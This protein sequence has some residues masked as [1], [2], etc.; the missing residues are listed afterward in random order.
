[1]FKNYLKLA[2]RNLFKQKLFSGLNILGLAT[3]L[4]SSIF[5]FLWVQDEISYD[6]FNVNAHKIYRI[7]T[8]LS[9]V[10]IANVPPPLAAAVK[11]EI[12]L[13]KNSTRL[14]SVKKVVTAGTSRF[15]EKRIYYTDSNFLNVFSYPLL[16]GEAA[17]VLTAPDAVVITEST[18]RKYFGKTEGAIGKTIYID[19]NIDGR[20][21]IVTGIL[22]DVPSNSHL[23]FDILLPIETYDK[24]G[25][26]GVWDNYSA[27]VYFQLGK[28]VKAT[29]SL[30]KRIEDQINL[31]KN[32][33]DKSKIQSKLSIQLL[34][35]IHLH[36]SFMDDVDGQGNAK[37]VTI[38]S[39]IAILILLIA[40]INFTNLSTAISSK[41]AK[42]VG[43][44]KTT[45]AQ[46]Y[47]LIGQFIGESVLLSLASLVIAI[48]VVILLLPLFNELASKSISITVLSLKVVGILITASVVIGIV[49]GSYPAFILSSF[50]PIRVLKGVTLFQGAK[51]SLRGGLVVLQFS[52]SVVL[53]IS[54]LVVYKQLQFIQQRDIG[55]DKENLLYIHMPEVGDLKDNKDALKAILRNHSAV[56]NYTITDHL[57]TYLKS[58]GPLTWTG[59]NSRKQVL[60]ARMRTDENFI[61]TFGVPLLAGRFFSGEI[62]SDEGMYVINETALKAMNMTL[63]NVIGQK[64]KVHDKE[65]TV[66]GV[67]KD[68]NFKPLQ[69]PV[70]PLVIKNNSSGGY[71]VVR[72]TQ[73][74]FKNVLSEMK[75]VFGKLY[76]D[77]PFS[78]GFVD[79]EMAR[80]YIAEERMSKL[81]N[82][83]SIL[84][85]LI[86][87]L[88]LFGLT[89]FSIQNRVK[90]IGIRK[91]IGASETS[92]VTLISKDFIKLVA[93][94]L[95]IAFPIASIVMN[96]W[97]NSFAYH[98]DM[99]WWMFAFGGL[100]AI[101]I[102][103]VTIS[104][105]AIKAAMA[106]P[107]KSLRA[108]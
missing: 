85:I 53:I 12:P 62:K 1:M 63:S 38:F 21:L 91:V 99:T 69:E 11:A 45:G 9:D 65:G 79:S 19:D 61:R 13:I 82:I 92:I 68:F 75:K 10:S 83:F 39:L 108:E 57:P 17:T 8:Q 33:N 35:D 7:T 29:P 58:A 25:N 16:Q 28:K 26:A 93:L 23:Q 42:E 34:T 27:Y 104:F 14:V 47:Q 64:I 5:I 3:G 66:I 88:G 67:I 41:R 20:N 24:N 94:A 59:M 18:A 60:S 86:S 101:L 15:E 48:L 105:Q 84:S 52:I 96:Q 44:R 6:N 89:T 56:S 74:N 31:I 106:N 95:I 90:E 71:A 80:L 73:A 70:G 40:C 81:F 32:R 46:R 49:A 43:L 87:S 50:N 4:T 98:I 78:F 77:Y 97:L 36:S 102:A 51:S 107:V 103:I 55:F 37:H 72:T 22:K 100:V 2:I 54:T 30:I 76:S